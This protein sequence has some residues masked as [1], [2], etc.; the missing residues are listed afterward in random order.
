MLLNTVKLAIMIDDYF[1]C[2]L[3]LKNSGITSVGISSISNNIAKVV[4]PVGLSK[5]TQNLVKDDFGIES[6]LIMF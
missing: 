6:V 5:Y 1:F 3:D 2:H 4:G